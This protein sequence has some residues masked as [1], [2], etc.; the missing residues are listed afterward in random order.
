MGLLGDDWSDPR[1][2]AAL[3]MGAGL[4]AAGG[5]S[6]TP[7][8]F[9]MGLSAGLGQYQEAMAAA[10]RQEVEKAKIEELKARA[11]RLRELEK[12]GILPDDPASIREWREFQ[13]MSP[14]DQLRYLEMKRQGYEIGVIGGV[15]T[16]LSRLPG[17]DSEPLS[18]LPTEVQGAAAIAGG[19]QRAIEGEKAAFDLVE[20]LD[21]RTGRLGF[22]NRLSVLPGIG[23]GG[24][25][26][27]QP[28]TPPVGAPPGA[29]VG[30]Y[31][32][33]G[34][35]TGPGMIPGREREPALAIQQAAGVE[36]VKAD[37][38]N[39]GE[40]P[41]RISQAEGAIEGAKTVIGAIDSATS[42]VNKWSAGPAAALI[43]NVP[44]V[45]QQAIDLQADIDTII[46]NIGFDKLQKM[47]W[48]S[49]TGGALGNV[50][51][52]ELSMLQSTL[53]SLKTE[54]SPQ[55]LRSKLGEVKRVYQGAMEKWNR[56]IAAENEFLSSRGRA[57]RTGGDSGSS[58]RLRYNPA[59]GRLE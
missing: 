49:P 34:A 59:T 36:R 19:K 28:P 32:G 15:P 40:A 1:T 48:E 9:G 16:R 29:A 27:A 18:T 39:E 31:G 55:Q 50:A 57:P 21:P 54:Q 51:V 4:L 47:R 53:A 7:V 11:L 25:M 14:A 23:G 52:Q 6:R 8:N 13:T 20:G 56:A 26:G 30:G 41:K 33:P 44:F 42:K 17:R 2:M 45:G 38:Q 22:T 58:T 35:A 24:A 46:A 43:K 37:I 5:P 10:Q 3:Q 12:K